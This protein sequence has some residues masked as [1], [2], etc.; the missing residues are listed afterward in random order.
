MFYPR[1]ADA[2]LYL[3]ACSYPDDE[4]ALTLFNFVW[5]SKILTVE[6]INTMGRT[7]QRYRMKGLTLTVVFFGIYQ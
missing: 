5:N 6:P 2:F 7:G 3:P 4:P 1:Q